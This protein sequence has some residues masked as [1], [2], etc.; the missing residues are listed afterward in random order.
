[1]VEGHT[2]AFY[3]TARFR[4]LTREFVFGPSIDN[5]LV[6]RL[7]NRFPH[8]FEQRWA[9]IFPA[10]FLLFRLEVVKAHVMN[11]KAACPSRIWT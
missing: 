10:W 1:M 9:W 5:N 4:V 8:G 6:H 7:A 11:A 2:N 3:T